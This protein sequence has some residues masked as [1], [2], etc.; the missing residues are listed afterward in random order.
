MAFCLAAALPLFATESS[1]SAMRQ[2]SRTDAWRVVM[3]TD[4]IE[5]RDYR[6]RLISRRDLQREIRA[7]EQAVAHEAAGL[8]SMGGLKALLNYLDRSNLVAAALRGELPA[9]HGGEKI[10]ALTPQ[11]SP[12]VRPPAACVVGRAPDGPA[13]PVLS[14]LQFTLTP[15]RVRVQVL[16]L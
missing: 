4:G 9:A 13:A 16:L 11:R 15:G 6:N 3:H 1:R 14:P 5:L 7:G 12:K 10:S 8:S 2:V